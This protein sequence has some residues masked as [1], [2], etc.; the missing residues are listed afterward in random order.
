MF[1]RLNSY[2]PNIRLTIEVNPSRFLDTKLTN[3][4]STYKFNFYWKNTKLPSPWFSKTPKRYKENAINGD[5]H[6]SKRISSKFNE[7]I[8]LIKVKLMNADYVLHFIN[9]V[10]NEFQ[11]GKECRDKKFHKFTS[12]SFR[13]VIMWKTRNIWSLFRLKDIKDYK[14]CVIYKGD[15]SC[16]SRY[17]GENSKIR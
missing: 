12:N 9:S 6:R 3:I 16:G 4:S 13:M 1:C 11:K 5:L 2:H 8:P 17:T 10:V 14:S 7:E 15:C